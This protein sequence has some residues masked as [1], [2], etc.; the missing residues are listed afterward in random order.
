M[1]ATPLLDFRLYRRNGRCPDMEDAVDPPLSQAVV[2]LPFKYGKSHRGAQ[3]SHTKAR[4]NAR[5]SRACLGRIY[6]S[7]VPG[8]SAIA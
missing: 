1:Q 4:A 3:K 2:N 6:G 7:L 5:I 8:K